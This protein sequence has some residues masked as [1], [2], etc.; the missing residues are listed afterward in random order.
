VSVQNKPVERA[1]DPRPARTRAAIVGAV[2]EVIA[3]P[4]AR[5]EI[6]VNAI[7]RAA[8]VSRSAFYAQFSDLDEL[9]VALLVDA[10]RDIGL[11]DVDARREPGADA[12][13]LAQESSRRLVAHIDE[14]RAFYRASLDWRLSGRVHESVVDAYAQQVLATMAVLDAG[15]PPDVVP[16][17]AAR[18]IA[19]GAIAVLTA[20][21]RDEAPGGRD[22]MAD[23]LV[24][25]MPDWLVGTA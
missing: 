8:G 19:G 13:T 2:S 23:R 15:V 5:G 9:A 3:D 6:S 24:A 7:A 16:E 12:R 14:R 22:A 11:D 10:F 18:F 20:W 21:L 17:D 4:A 1:T 25:V